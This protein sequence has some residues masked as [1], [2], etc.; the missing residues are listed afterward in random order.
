MQFAIKI[1][2]VSV[3][4]NR[5]FPILP[6]WSVDPLSLHCHKYSPEPL[7][8]LLT[9]DTQVKAKRIEA[10]INPWEETLLWEI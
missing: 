10:E 2:S 3:S 7:L 4:S 9:T 6:C 5:H 8:S 1:S